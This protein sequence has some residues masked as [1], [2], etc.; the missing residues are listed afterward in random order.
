M[1]NLQYTE[2]TYVFL[3]IVFLSDPLNGENFSMSC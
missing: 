3:A 2:E 1:G